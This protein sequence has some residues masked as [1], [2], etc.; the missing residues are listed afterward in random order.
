MRKSEVIKACENVSCVVSALQGLHDVIVD[1]QKI[2]L[3]AAIEAGVRRFIPSD[4]S[5]DFTKLPSGNNHNFDLRREFHKY[6]DEADIKVTSIFNG[7]F[8]YVLSFGTPLL[9]KKNKT[10]GYWE[11]KADWKIDYTTI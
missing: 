5:I 8:S 4:Y 2:L 9:N 1:A 6:L 11:G 10:V 7:A 3:D